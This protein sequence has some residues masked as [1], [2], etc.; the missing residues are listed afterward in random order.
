MF[1]LFT[2]LNKLLFMNNKDKYEQKNHRR[3]LYEFL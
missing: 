1:S 2:T 3:T